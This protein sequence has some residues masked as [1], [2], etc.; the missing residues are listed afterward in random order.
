M[1]YAS[2]AIAKTYNQWKLNI[3]G[4]ITNTT[5][6]DLIVTIGSANTGYWHTIA[7]FVDEL[8]NAIYTAMIDAGFDSTEYNSLYVDIDYNQDPPLIFL[9][10]VGDAVSFKGLGASYKYVDRVI[11]GDGTNDSDWTNPRYAKGLPYGLVCAKYVTKDTDDLPT[12]I[13][14]VGATLGDSHRAFVWGKKHTR[15]IEW[16]WLTADEWRN[17]IQLYEDYQGGLLLQDTPISVDDDY[18]YVIIEP[19][20]PTYNRPSKALERYH[21][22]FKLGKI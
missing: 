12:L 5:G 16:Q 18:N 3:K 22:R 9:Y 2:W 8:G 15:E 21:V 10:S 20:S 7:E 17:I 14:E 13:G 6:V 11:G 19:T 4:T 1:H